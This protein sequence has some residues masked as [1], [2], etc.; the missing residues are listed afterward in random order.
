[1]V[2]NKKIILLRCLI[3]RKMPNFKDFLKMEICGHQQDLFKASISANSYFP[4]NKFS[5]VEFLT[6]LT[7]PSCG[8]NTQ[9]S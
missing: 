2:P 9:T 8:I 1:M 5:P 7:V 6:G 3:L 4:L